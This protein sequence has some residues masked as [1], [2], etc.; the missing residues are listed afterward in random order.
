LNKYLYNVKGEIEVNIN[1][2]SEKKPKNTTTVGE[3]I[4]GECASVFYVYI[5]CT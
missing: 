1:N 5:S 3:L 2:N 4:A